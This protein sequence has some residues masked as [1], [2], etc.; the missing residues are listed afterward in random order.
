MESLAR[1]SA[2]R[3]TGAEP[4]MAAGRPVGATVADFWGWSR[5]GRFTRPVAAAGH[6][7]LENDRQGPRRSFSP[8]PRTCT[9]MP[10]CAFGRLATRVCAM[11]SSVVARLINQMLLARMSLDNEGMPYGNHQSG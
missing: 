8:G 4:F 10:M 1:V 2:S 6:R 5:T 11:T 3:N 9:P 7:A